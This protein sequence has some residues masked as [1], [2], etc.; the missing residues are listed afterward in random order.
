M[1]EPK[2]KLTRTL[3][4]WVIFTTMSWL[5][6]SCKMK[7]KEGSLI[8]RAPNTGSYEIYKIASE[9]PLQFVS[10]QVG[11]FNEPL[12]LNPGNYLI[13]GDCSFETV[14]IRPEETHTLTA[15]Q[16]IFTPP[17]APTDRD[18]FSIQCNRFTKTKSRQHL[19]NRFSL[20][21]LHGTRDLLVGMIP[22]RIEFPQSEGRIEPQTLKYNLSGIQVKDYL[23]MKPKTSFF[24]SPLEGLLS[25]TQNQEFG[26]WQFLMPGHYLVE[27][28]GTRME[29]TL[30][31]GQQL[32]IEPGFLKVSVS[33]SVNLQASSN[34]LG[35]PLYVE[36][37]QGHWL[38]LNEQYAVLPGEASLKLNGSLNAHKILLQEGTVLEKKARSV[39]IALDCSPW[40]WACLGSREIYL[41]EQDKPYPF[42]EGISDVPLLFFEEDAWVSVQGSR[43]IRYKVPNLTQD[44]N[45]KV[46]FVKLVP[47]Q[48]HRP[49]QLTDLSRI[50]ALGFPFAGHSLDLPSDTDTLMPLIV[51]R[52]SLTQFHA[53]AT[54][55]WER[56]A[57]RIP[58]SV[59]SQETLEVPYPVFVSDKKLKQIHESQNQQLLTEQKNKFKLRQ[60]KFRPLVSA[61]AD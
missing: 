57:N 50:E 49:G 25:I 33:D 9:E 34:I 17:V 23:G 60:W 28:N 61:R 3:A 21:V 5:S 48:Q 11:K 37:N 54:A 35:T 51:G 7:N 6:S 55:E 4:L 2:S 24:V 22:L 19:Q 10:E 8:V 1:E 58:F 12:A 16:V 26:H 36:L 53:Y 45:L 32:L 39:T 13:L 29:T 40:D 20:N 14:V 59:S 42:A 15:H 46:G 38:D 41:Y 56:R 47:K 44:T 30:T 18:N 43:D 27:V 31:E 52:Y